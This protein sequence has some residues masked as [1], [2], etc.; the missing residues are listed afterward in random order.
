MRV[1]HRRADILMSQ[2]LLQ[3]P[4]I[5]AILQKVGGEGVSERVHGIRILAGAGFALP[6]QPLT[7]RRAQQAA[8]LRFDTTLTDNPVTHTIP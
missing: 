8:P 5:I 2:K 4:N 7:P 3:R 1:H 6:N